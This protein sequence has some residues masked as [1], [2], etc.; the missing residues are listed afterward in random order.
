MRG[1]PLRPVSLKKSAG[2]MAA[3]NFYRDKLGVFK[4]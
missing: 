1:Q 2:I 4:L 3:V